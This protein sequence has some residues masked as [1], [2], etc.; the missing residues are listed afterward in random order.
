MEYFSVIGGLILLVIAGDK[1]VDGAVAIAE[2]LHVSKLVIGITVVSFGTS[3]PELVVGVDA[4]LSGAADL[5][6]GNVVGSNIANVLMVL[7]VPALLYP[8]VCDDDEIRHNLIFMLLATVLLIGLSFFAPLHIWQ[9]LL[10]VSLLAAFLLYAVRRAK[11]NAAILRKET[12]FAAHAL[13][14]LE[15]TPIKKAP[16]FYS[17]FTIILGLAGLIFGAH[18]LVNGAITIARTVGV[19]E[20]V[21]GLTIVAIGTSLPE[22][23]TSISA[24]R[25][26]HGDVA[27]GNIIGSNLFNILAIM[28]ITSLVAPINIPDEFM[29]VDFWIFLASSL[30]LVPYAMG[31]WKIN[32]MTGVLFI[33]LYVGYLLYLASQTNLVG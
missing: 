26:K 25:N 22:L 1:L 27:M 30:L 10:M 33:G 14:D 21:I 2:R 12:Q 3:A 17:I 31:K 23:V 15:Q 24:A 8:F 13:Q 19:S 7:G 9:G 6:L 4:A 11:S 20:A 29:Q 5:A 32:R 16:L 28:G 18:I